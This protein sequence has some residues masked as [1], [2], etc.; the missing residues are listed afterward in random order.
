MISAVV[1]IIIA[2]SDISAQGAVSDNVL[3]SWVADKGNDKLLPLKIGEQK[4]GSLKE[5]TV[6]KEGVSLITENAKIIPITTNFVINGKHCWAICIWPYN[7]DEPWLNE[8]FQLII[9]RDGD[10]IQLMQM[11][12]GKKTDI[13]YVMDKK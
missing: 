9:G 1:M 8:Q 12:D 6:S 10:R 4:V 13:R 2:I 7:N 5:I 11:I 3:G